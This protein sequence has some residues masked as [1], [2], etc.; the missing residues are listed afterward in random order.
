MPLK[1]YYSRDFDK[2]CSGKMIR[3]FITP[4]LS[5]AKTLC[6]ARV[7][8]VHLAA[9]SPCSLSGSSQNLSIMNLLL[10]LIYIF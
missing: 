9:R 1:I 2:V 5:V 6:A 3:L 8:F 10:L 7:L 4:N